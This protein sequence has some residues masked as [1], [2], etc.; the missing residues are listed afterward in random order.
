MLL[1]QSNPIDTFNNGIIFYSKRNT[2]V[3]FACFKI[4]WYWFRYRFLIWSNWYQFLTLNLYQFLRLLF[5]TLKNL[6]PCFQIAKKCQF[7]WVT[8]RFGATWVIPLNLR[9]IS[10][11]VQRISRIQMIQ[12]ADFTTLNSSIFQVYAR[13]YK[14]KYDILNIIN[15]Y[16]YN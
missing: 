5:A 9:Q 15:N 7:L 2:V 6:K 16:Y 13:Y 12:F 11:I 10:S 8:E 4:T 3:A 1:R 14:C